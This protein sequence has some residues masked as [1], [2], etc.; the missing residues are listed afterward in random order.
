TH[1]FPGAQVLAH[2][3]CPDNILDYADYIG[4]TSGILNFAKTSDS[5]EF[6]IA[7]EPGIIHTMQK[8]LPHKLFYAI[9][10]L[11]GC[12]CNE[13]PHMKLNTIDKMISA[14]ENL[15]PEII[16]DEDLRLKALKAI[17]KMLELS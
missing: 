17:E 5:K 16:L 15:K 3:E 12:S 13:C 6:I 7:T 10:N 4:S 1:A 11:L 8:A 2:P 9:P 14:L